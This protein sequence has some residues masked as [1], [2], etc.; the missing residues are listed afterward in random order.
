MAVSRMT[1]DYTKSTRELFADAVNGNIQKLIYSEERTIVNDVTLRN[2]FTEG[3]PTTLLMMTHDQEGDGFPVGTAEPFD[4]SALVGY[5]ELLI[6]R[7]NMMDFV[8]DYNAIN[9]QIGDILNIDEAPTEQSIVNSLNQLLIGAG[10]PAAFVVEDITH[11]VPA[12]GYLVV[13]YRPYQPF[14]YG[15]FRVSA[16]FEEP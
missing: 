4:E 15:Q 12:D 2:E 3:S 1:R 10:A 8:R 16:T 13:Q 11:I 6:K 5:P 7:Y 14:F 9:G